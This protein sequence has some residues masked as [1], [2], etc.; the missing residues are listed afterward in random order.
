MPR[1][2]PFPYLKY[3]S[4]TIGAFFCLLTSACDKQKQ[5]TATWE[6]ATLQAS[7]AADSQQ[8]AAKPNAAKPGTDQSPAPETT[9]SADVRFLAYN[10][11]NYLTMRRWTNDKAVYTG[12][13]GEEINALITITA[14]A[15]PDVLG[16][17]EIGTDADLRDFQKRLKAA[18]TDLPHSHRVTGIDEVRS[19]AI[20]SRYPIISTAAPE[21]LGYTLNGTGFA[22]SRGILD[23]TV[24]LPK[25]KVRFLGIHFKSTPSS[26]PTAKSDS[27]ASTSNQNVPPR[28]PTRK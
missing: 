19:L 8:P 23:A 18:G 24:Q 3:A 9:P 2:K 25:R 13:P 15:K 16:I 22:V 28:K 12:K 5:S 21:K 4:I 17:C 6:N 1:R 11:R 27:S 10:L 7:T 26:S 14:S 20:L